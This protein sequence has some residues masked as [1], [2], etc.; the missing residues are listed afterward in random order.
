[1]LEAIKAIIIKHGGQ[2]AWDELVTQIA[3]KPSEMT[4]EEFICACFLVANKY[5]I[6]NK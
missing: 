1:M 5:A 2:K 6:I 3:K 4:K